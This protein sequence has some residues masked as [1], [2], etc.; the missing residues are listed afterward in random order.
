VIDAR[1]RYD[2]NI[3]WVVEQAAAV[4]SARLGRGST[5]EVG[6]GGAVSVLCFAII[7]L[8][9]C[10]VT[11]IELTPGRNLTVVAPRVISG[12]EPHYLMVLNSILDHDLELQD[13]YERLSRGGWRPVVVLPAHI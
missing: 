12:D 13:D 3:H 1:D 11:R 10:G 5:D 9:Y 2:I 6:N 7:L 8:L 4:C